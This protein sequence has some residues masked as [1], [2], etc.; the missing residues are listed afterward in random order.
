MGESSVHRVLPDL[1]PSPFEY[2]LELISSE[3]PRFPVLQSCA[4]HSKPNI[5]PG[6]RI[7]DPVERLRVFGVPRRL[8]EDKRLVGGPRE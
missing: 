7:R 1:T 6:W 4:T 3:T 2:C 5:R 8:W